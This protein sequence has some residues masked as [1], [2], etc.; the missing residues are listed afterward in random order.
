MALACFTTRRRHRRAHRAHRKA[1]TARNSLA[2]SAVAR[3]RQ[4]HATKRRGTASDR[5]RIWAAGPRRAARTPRAK[6]RA[7]GADAS[8]RRATAAVAAP[9]ARARAACAATASC[10]ADAA[11]C[12]ATSAGVSPSLPSPAE[13]SRASLL[14][15]RAAPASSAPTHRVI[16]PPTCAEERSPPRSATPSQRKS[17]ASAQEG[18]RSTPQRRAG[19]RAAGAPSAAHAM[20]SRIVKDLGSRWLANAKGPPWRAR[21]RSSLVQTIGRRGSEAAASSISVAAECGGGSGT[22]DGAPPRIC[23]RSSRG[24]GESSP[25][26]A[27]PTAFASSAWD[28]ASMATTRAAPWSAFAA[29]ATSRAARLQRSEPERCTKRI[30]GI[31]AGDRSSAALKG[32]A[33]ATG[34]RHPKAGL[35]VR[36]TATQRTPR[37]GAPKFRANRDH[38]PPGP[39]PPSTA[40]AARCAS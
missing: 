8:L 28:S 13:P 22:A 11:A 6:H 32:D 3:Q 2:A 38:L 17:A 37:D 35:P 12:S 7:H 24:Y 31:A 30:T 29:A 39:P 18:P 27:A 15:R 36:P 14:R 20:R 21:A 40:S 26:C 34:E 1:A 4:R 5:S 19:L 10:S 33:S 25:C 9:L 23:K 16:A